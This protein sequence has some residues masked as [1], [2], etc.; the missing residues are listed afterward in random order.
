MYTC[1]Y[2]SS[3]SHGFATTRTLLVWSVRLETY[4]VFTVITKLRVFTKKWV[5]GS[6][7]AF[8]VF[9]EH[10]V[11][12]DTQIKNPFSEWL[13]LASYNFMQ[14]PTRDPIRH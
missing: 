14:R 2:S 8:N 6:L 1:Y 3:Q 9:R 7:K 11:E 13:D 10:L 12:V 5:N 4:F